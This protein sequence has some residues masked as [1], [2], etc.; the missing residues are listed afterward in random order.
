VLEGWDGGTPRLRPQRSRATLRQL[1]SHRSG[2]AYDTWN[3][4]VQRYRRRAGLPSARSGRMAALT[5]PLAFDPGAGWAYGMGLDWAG[6]LIEA[7]DGRRI[8]VFCREEIFAPLGMEETGFALTPALA[9]RLAALRVRDGA[10]FVVVEAPTLIEPEFHGLGHG[11]IG[12][13][14]DYLRFLSML[15]RGGELDGRRLLAEATVAEL[16]ANQI[17]GRRLGVIPSFQPEASAD[18]DFRLGGGLTWSLLGLRSE[19][20][21]PGRRAAGAQGWGGVLNTLYW[22]D[23]AR[24]RAGLLMTQLRPYADQ[25]VTAVL[26]DFER[27]VHGR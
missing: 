20:A 4:G 19:A 12:T 15:L 26:A 21:V 8:D 1:L 25:R 10:G 16:L 9:P 22:L 13:G 17:G 27:A 7:V 24:R 6:L 2:A 23:P 5:L 11:L 18:V 3:Q 14:G